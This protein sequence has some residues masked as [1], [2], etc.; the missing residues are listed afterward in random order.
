MRTP[1]AAR[2]IHPERIDRHAVRGV[3]IV[4]TTPVV[5][6]HIGPNRSAQR[7]AVSEHAATWLLLDTRVARVLVVHG[8]TASELAAELGHTGYV[9]VACSAELDVWAAAR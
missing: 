9:L 6:M 7:L 1:P 8:R 2:V 5:R 3:A 4:H